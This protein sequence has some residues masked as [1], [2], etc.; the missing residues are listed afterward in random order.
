MKEAISLP[1]VEQLFSKD[2]D[3]QR[4]HDK[5]LEPFGEVLDLLDADQEAGKIDEGQ[6]ISGCEQC[7]NERQ[8]AS[9]EFKQA[10][11]LSKLL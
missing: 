4:D 5:T 11:L 1:I 7:A 3:A 8:R 9:D 2:V 6:Y 10:W